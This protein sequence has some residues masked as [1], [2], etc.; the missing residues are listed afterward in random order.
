M[1]NEKQGDHKYYQEEKKYEAA[2]D[3]FTGDLAKQYKVETIPWLKVT[4]AVVFI[5]LILVLL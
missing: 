3:K 2:V 5:F 4:E 1:E